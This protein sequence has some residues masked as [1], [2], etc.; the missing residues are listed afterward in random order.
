MAAGGL[1]LW[2][3]FAAVAFAAGPA[4]TAVTVR[5]GAVSLAG[6]ANHRHGERQ[7]ECQCKDLAH[8]TLH[9]GVHVALLHMKILRAMLAAAGR[10]RFL[11]M[12]AAVATA[13][14]PAVT[15]VTIRSGPVSL[16]RI[17]NYRHGEC[18][19]KCQC[20]DLAHL[21]LHFDGHVTTILRILARAVLMTARRRCLRRMLAPVA[22]AAGFA[23]TAV[24]IRSRA[25]SLARI[26]NYRH[27]KR[28][29]ERQ[30]ENLAHLTL[31]FDGHAG[32]L[33]LT[34]GAV[35]A[36]PRRRRL[37]RMLAAVAAAA[38][39]AVATV[40]IRS[41]TVGLAGIAE[42]RHH[43]RQNKGQYKYLSHVPLQLHGLIAD[44]AKLYRD[45]VP[46]ARTYSCMWGIFR[47]LCSKGHEPKPFP[48]AFP[49]CSSLLIA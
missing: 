30:H 36:A 9:F 28:Q 22:A 38:G 41:W 12:L 44:V 29:N 4:V 16:A 11:L 35:L 33:H 24:T 45:A 27:G 20:K 19:H 6:I 46:A 37:R 49:Y 21:V 15:A 5:S 32:I 8:L 48:P 14:G 18:Q 25:V 2:R 42:R 7:N 3:M 40:A 26:A 43:E 39:F 47:S 23:V 31:H 13:F 34:V 10:R 1:C 17:A